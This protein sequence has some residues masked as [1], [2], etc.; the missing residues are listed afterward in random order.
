R[1]T[2][3]LEILQ[4]PARLEGER[5]A[6]RVHL[7]HQS[8]H[9]HLLNEGG[10]SPSSCLIAHGER[11]GSNGALSPFGGEGWKERQ[12]DSA[13]SKPGRRSMGAVSR[14]RRRRASSVAVLSTSSVAASSTTP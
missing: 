7:L 2:A 6:H 5:I 3:G 12:R 14:A 9:M 8:V 11:F 1:G 10:R 13:C 4:V